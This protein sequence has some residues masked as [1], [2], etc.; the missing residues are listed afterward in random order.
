MGIMAR[1]PEGMLAFSHLVTHVNYETTLPERHRELV[2]LRVAHVRGSIYEWGQH[3]YQAAQAGLSPLEITRVKSGPDSKG[4]SSFEASLL[5]AVDQLVRDAR[6]DDATYTELL[7]ELD[8][9]QLMD[10]IFTVAAYDAFAMFMRTFDVPLD[11]D[12]EP[13]ATT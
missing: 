3:I 6:I 8:V 5:R 9:R 7:S 13:Y 1:H 2:V 11:A 10:V 4:W 12:L